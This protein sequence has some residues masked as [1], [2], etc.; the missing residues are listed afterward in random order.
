MPSWMPC[1]SCPFMPRLI[2]VFDEEKPILPNGQDAP[3]FSRLLELEMDA[4][5][6]GAPEAS[7]RIIGHVRRI[8]GAA[9][10]RQ[11]PPVIRGH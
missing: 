6:H 11:Y 4:E 8:A 5:R 3:L 9:S 1:L 7:C 2:V 10:V